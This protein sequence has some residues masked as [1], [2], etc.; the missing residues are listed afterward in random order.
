MNNSLVQ[1]KIWLRKS[2]ADDI[3]EF[4]VV[5]NITN[6][7]LY[8]MMLIAQRLLRIKY[9]DFFLTLDLT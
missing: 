4:L 9:G 8:D 7:S 1:T 3:R 5:I 2:L 6:L